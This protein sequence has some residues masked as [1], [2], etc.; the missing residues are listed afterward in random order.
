VTRFALL[1]P[2]GVV[3]A[4]DARPLEG[5]PR[6]RAQVA[7]LLETAPTRALETGIV[8]AP[9]L[10]QRLQRLAAWVEARCAH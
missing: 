1:T 2:L 7:Q 9:T 3:R 8:T 6:I 4:L 5:V 10:E